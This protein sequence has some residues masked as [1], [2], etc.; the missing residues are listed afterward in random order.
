M[1]GASAASIAV[2]I[3]RRYAVPPSKGDLTIPLPDAVLLAVS[4]LERLCLCAVLDPIALAVWQT[5]HK[6]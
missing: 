6:H 3:P 4:G 5:R 2:N 1:L